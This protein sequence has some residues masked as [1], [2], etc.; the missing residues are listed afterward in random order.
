MHAC[1]PYA[2]LYMHTLPSVLQV[3]YVGGDKPRS[4]CKDPGSDAAVHYK[5]ALGSL[6]RNVSVA[7]L[8]GKTPE[9]F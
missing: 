6:V 8:L 7:V 3:E 9:D 2:Y 1:I 4:E 5:E